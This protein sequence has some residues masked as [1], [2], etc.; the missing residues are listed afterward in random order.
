MTI[1]LV[2]QNIVPVCLANT[3]FLY[4]QYL[5]ESTFL[6]YYCY[7][8]YFFG[9]RDKVNS[10]CAYSRDITVL[11][12]NFHGFHKFFPSFAKVKIANCVVLLFDHIR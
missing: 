1:R 4:S 10:L 2:K 7:G 12:C 9:G 5:L 8:S 11:G 6:D 3:T